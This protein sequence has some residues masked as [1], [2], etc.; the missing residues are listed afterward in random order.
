VNGRAIGFAAAG[1][2]VAA[3]GTTALGAA[4]AAAGPAYIGV[5]PLTAYVRC[6]TTGP[7]ATVHAA[8]GQL[9]VSH[10]FFFPFAWPTAAHGGTA[11]GSWQVRKYALTGA[12]YGSGTSTGRNC[13]RHG[14]QQSHA[15]SRSQHGPPWAAARTGVAAVTT[16]ARGVGQLVPEQAV[17]VRPPNQP[18][19]CRRKPGLF[20]HGPHAS[21]GH[22]TVGQTGSGWPITGGARTGLQYAGPHGFAA[23]GQSAAGRGGLPRANAGARTSIRA[24]NL[25]RFIAT[26]E[27]GVRVRA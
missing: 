18:I 19:T 27:R 10:A 7:T 8:G 15:F 13:S 5:H 20:S 14:F 16:A 17:A 1:F 11:V 9:P 3:A 25:Y 6:G 12:W 2:T 26:S 23:G 22:G 21:G 24:T 4:G